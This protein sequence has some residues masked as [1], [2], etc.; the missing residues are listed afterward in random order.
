MRPV[1]PHEGWLVG[2]IPF[3]LKFWAKL[4]TPSETPSEKSSTV[5]LTGSPLSNEPKMNSIC[6]L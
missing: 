2:Y 6:C 4:A 1:L 5:T 3:Y